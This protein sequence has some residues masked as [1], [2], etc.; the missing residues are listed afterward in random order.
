M[1][2]NVMEYVPSSRRGS[3][4]GEPEVGDRCEVMLPSKEVF[5]GVITYIDKGDVF[6]SNGLDEFH[7]KIQHICPLGWYSGSIRKGMLDM[8][9]F[10]PSNPHTY[11]MKPDEPK[12]GI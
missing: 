2:I 6:V 5:I 10:Q 4:H 7:V 11:K 9:I 3:V 8:P 1:S 12:E